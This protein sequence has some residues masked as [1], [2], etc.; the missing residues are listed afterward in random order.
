MLIGILCRVCLLTG[1]MHGFFGYGGRESAD[2]TKKDSMIGVDSRVITEVVP[3]E[4]AHYAQLG[5]YCRVGVAVEAPIHTR[6][7]EVTA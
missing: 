4:P 6:A 3:M 2:A 7:P 5:T 1:L